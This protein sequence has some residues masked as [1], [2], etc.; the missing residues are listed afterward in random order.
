MINVSVALAQCVIHSPV[1]DEDLLL[2]PGVGDLKLDKFIIRTQLLHGFQEM[3][4]KEL[5]D[6]SYLH[7]GDHDAVD[8]GGEAVQL[9]AHLERRAGLHSQVLVYQ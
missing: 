1:E 9:D 2:L 5:R 3:C 6:C 8:V 7:V 4:M